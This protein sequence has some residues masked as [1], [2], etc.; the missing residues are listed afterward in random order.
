MAGFFMVIFNI[1]WY[2]Q[3]VKNHQKHISKLSL[4][5]FFQ[6][7]IHPSLEG[8]HDDGGWWPGRANWSRIG[9][10]KYLHVFVGM[11]F[12]SRKLKKTSSKS[13]Y[14]SMAFPISKGLEKPPGFGDFNPLEKYARQIGSFPQVGVKI[15]HIWNHQLVIFF[16]TWNI[17]EWID[18]SSHVVCSGGRTRMNMM[19]R[20]LSGFQ[21]HTYVDLGK[22]L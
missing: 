10:N 2:I 11:F 21:P 22:L 1:P 3:S 4:S 15:K 20:K 18:S 7:Q 13:L 14:K 19:D 16:M 9:I 17:K 5:L 8:K 12:I 6:P